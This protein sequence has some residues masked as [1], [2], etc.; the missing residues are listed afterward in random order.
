MLLVPAEEARHVNGISVNVWPVVTITM[1][2]VPSASAESNRRGSVCNCPGQVLPS[3]ASFPD[4]P[5]VKVKAKIMGE[6]HR[7]LTSQKQT[8]HS[9]R[10]SWLPSSSKS[11]QAFPICSL[12]AAKYHH[13]VGKTQMSDQAHARINLTRQTAT[14]KYHW[15]E[16]GGI[17]LIWLAALKSCWPNLL[18][19]FDASDM[20]ARYPRIL[21]TFSVHYSNT[22]INFGEQREHYRD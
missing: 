16:K 13:R 9:V 8:A 3:F 1:L 11:R 20:L 7:T 4:L 2:H 15:H 18:Q 5:L 21:V 10:L 22:K 19:T 12:S 17:E 14:N 6:R